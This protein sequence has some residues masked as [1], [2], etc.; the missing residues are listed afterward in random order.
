MA[1]PLIRPPV[2]GIKV[3]KPWLVFRYMEVLAAAR[4]EKTQKRYL[5]KVTPAGPIPSD[6]LLGEVVK[7]KEALVNSPEGWRYEADKKLI[8]LPRS[9]PRALAM[10][11]WAHH[12]EKDVCPSVHMP[13]WA[14][15][16]AFRVDAIERE[17]LQAMQTADA[18]A[19]GLER[20][21]MDACAPELAG[22]EWFRGAWPASGIRGMNAY[23]TPLEAYR[24]IWD[25]Y[26][27]AVHKVSSYT[28]VLWAAN[29]LVYKLRLAPVDIEER[30]P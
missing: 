27:S 8:T 5:A 18:L 9:D 19:E 25:T 30:K 7:V 21:P 13:L 12:V 20:V 17:H 1:K 10:I 11:A 16:F 15:R 28:R 14:A 22:V 6:F 4:G 24:D 2:V 23:P 3:R 26:V 29:P